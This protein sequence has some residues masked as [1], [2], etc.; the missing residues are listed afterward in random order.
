MLQLGKLRDAKNCFKKNYYNYKSAIDQKFQPLVNLNDYP[1]KTKPDFLIIG[2]PKCGTSSLYRYLTNHPLIVPAT[3]K[4]L[5]LF[6]SPSK[7]KTIDWYLNQFPQRNK[8]S[9]LLTGEASPGY[10]P[11][12]LAHQH[13]FNLFSKIK[14]IVILRNPIDRAVFR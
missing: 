4:E 2:V 12:P 14:L 13:I 6:I 5:N 11:A 3:R 7:D 8:E 1:E 9:N 10:F